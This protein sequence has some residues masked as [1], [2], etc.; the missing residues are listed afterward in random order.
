SQSPAVQRLR[1]RCC[2]ARSRDSPAPW[3]SPAQERL[4]TASALSA[5][6]LRTS[7]E[8]TPSPPPCKPAKLR[9]AAL[10][11]HLRRSI[12]ATLRRISHSLQFLSRASRAN[13]V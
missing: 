1:I 6:L 10:L 4:P 8:P 11:R 9:R 7:V 2:S 12:R 13:A 3:R 5:R